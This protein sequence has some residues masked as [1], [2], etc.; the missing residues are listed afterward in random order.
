MEEADEKRNYV[1]RASSP[2]LET[3]RIDAMSSANMKNGAQPRESVILNIRPEDL[4][5]TDV[6]CC[7]GKVNPR[8]LSFSVKV[9]I[10]IFVLGFSMYKLY[11]AP[12]CGCSEDSVVYVSLITSILSVWVGANVGK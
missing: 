11:R 8:L 4:P 6:M 5:K 2:G 9:S 1:I 12:Q 3:R 10:S 7:G